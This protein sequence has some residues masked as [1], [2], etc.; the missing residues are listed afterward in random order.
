MFQNLD[1]SEKGLALV[2]PMPHRHQAQAGE[3]LAR[4]GRQRSLW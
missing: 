1:P 4:K 2:V 3:V